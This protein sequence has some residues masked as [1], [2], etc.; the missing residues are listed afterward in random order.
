MTTRSQA[1]FCSIITQCPQLGNTCT[2]TLGIVR[3]GSNAMSTG[4]TRSSRPHVMQGLGLDLV[5]HRPV[6][7]R[8]A[9]LRQRTR[10]E[11]P[12][13]H[14]SYIRREKVEG[15][16]LGGLLPARLD[17]LV[18]DHRLVEDHRLQPLD[19]ALARRV[20][21]E[22]HQQVDAL[23]GNGAEDVLAHAADGDQAA[24]PVG[25]LD[26][27]LGRD[28]AAHG[29]ADDVDPCRGRGRRG[30]LI[31]DAG[32]WPS[33]GCWSV[34][35]LTPKPGEFVEHQAAEVL[36]ECGQVALVVAPAGDSRAGAVEQQERR[37]LSHV[38]VPQHTGLGGDLLEV[39]LGRHGCSM[40]DRR[41]H[42]RDRP[43]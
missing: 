27:E 21:G 34:G 7:R 18:G 1:S 37:T 19:E 31:T 17:Q 43:H 16:G 32:A 8:V 25:V 39:G 22:L 35:S 36:R 12:W 14:C 28:D 2:S 41:S 30:R 33:I 26:R 15:L 9:P 11:Q 24:H 4:L 29:V 10:R 3:I 20:V 42:A 23:T 40:P 6:R 13:P 38:V 5:Q